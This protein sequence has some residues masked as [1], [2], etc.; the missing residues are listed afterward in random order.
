MLEVI[1]AYF[2][3]QLNM[4]RKKAT[5]GA[6]HELGS[7]VAFVL[8]GEPVVEHGYTLNK[9]QMGLVGGPGGFAMLKA[10]FKAL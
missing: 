9:M 2:S 7:A 3:E 8:D 10:F 5:L 4:S 1:V 6:G